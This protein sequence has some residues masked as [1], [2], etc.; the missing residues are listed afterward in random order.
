MAAS[1]LIHRASMRGFIAAIFIMGVLRFILTIA[2]VSND[3]VRFFSMTGIIIVGAL[4]FTMATE[5]H[6]E[7]L[8][9]SYW[10]ILPY[11]V[12]EVVALGY[13]WISG[14]E[15]IFHAPEYSFGGTPLALH[16]IGHFIGGLT[17]EPLTVFLLMEVVWGIATIA[18]RVQLV[19]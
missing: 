6:K 4:Y 2:G 13:T 19:F 1:S 16:M 18:K 5:T 8:K 14:R 9:A 15:T 17:W 3:I 7:R 11:M 12:V 10:L